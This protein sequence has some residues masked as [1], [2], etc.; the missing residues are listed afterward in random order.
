MHFWVTLLL[1]FAGRALLIK[2][3]IC[4]I[5]AF[6]CNHFLLLHANIQSLLT[7]FMWKGNINHKG[8]AKVAWT[9]MCLSREQEGGLD[10]KNMIEWNKAQI[11]SH[12]LRI[13]TNSSILWATWVNK[14]V[15]RW[16]HF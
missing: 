13:V 1:S 14:T 6:W 9:T 7:R 11:L 12:L 15:L 4:A 2:S 5:E 10:I 8:G 16:K 3:V